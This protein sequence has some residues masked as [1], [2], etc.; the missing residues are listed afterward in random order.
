[1]SG[2]AVAK[3][4]DIVS[5]LRELGLALKG[6]KILGPVNIHGAGTERPTEDSPAAGQ[7]PERDAT[8]LAGGDQRE[9]PV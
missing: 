1:M 2:A 5:Q 6:A 9:P 4:I 3:R 7:H 8:R